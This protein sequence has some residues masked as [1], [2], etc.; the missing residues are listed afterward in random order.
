[1]TL[2]VEGRSATLADRAD[3][4]ERKALAETI[5]GTFAKGFQEA[6]KKP[7]R[8]ACA[9][10]SKALSSRFRGVSAR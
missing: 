9:P 6:F 8:P 3:P 7:C 1:M 10:A 4:G 5:L 2:M